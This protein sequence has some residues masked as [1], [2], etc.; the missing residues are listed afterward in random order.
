MTGKPEIYTEATETS[1]VGTYPI[2]AKPGTINAPDVTYEEG[3]LFVNKAT[4]TVTVEDATRKQYEED[5]QFVLHFEGFVNGEDESVITTMPTVTSNATIDSPEG[6]YV[7]TISGGDA[8]NY[9]FDYVSGKLTISGVVNAI[10]AVMVSES[11]PQDIYNLQGQLV[12]RSA[13][14]LSG[15]PAGTYIIS[16]RKL[17]VK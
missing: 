11:K 1:P 7:L 9:K 4:L 17:V 10:D 8:Q 5:P 16:G 12:R 6:E 3:I 13:T 15:L 14:S 2:Y